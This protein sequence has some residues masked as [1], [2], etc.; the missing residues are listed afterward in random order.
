MFRQAM[1]RAI[2]ANH[3]AR[4]YLGRILM[5]EDSSR[6]LIN[7]YAGRAMARLAEELDALRELE[8]IGDDEREENHND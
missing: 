7:L 8:G 6:Q 2:N 1:T 5:D 3:A 4:V